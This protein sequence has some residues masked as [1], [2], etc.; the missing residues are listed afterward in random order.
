MLRN[1]ADETDLELA[2]MYQSRFSRDPLPVAQVRQ[3]LEQFADAYA[4]DPVFQVLGPRPVVAISGTWHYSEEDLR[5]MT[6]SVASRLQILGTEKSVKGYERVAPVVQGNLYYWSSADPERTPSYETKLQAMSDAV[7]AHCGLWV[8]PVAPGFDARDVGGRS[9]VDRRDGKTL[10]SSW[11]ASTASAPDAL[12]VI[13]W[14]EY[15]ENTHIEPSTTFGTRYLDVLRELTGVGPRPARRPGAAPGGGVGADD[16]DGVRRHR[17]RAGGHG[18]GGPAAPAQ[19]AVR[20]GSDVPVGRGRGVRR[21]GATSVVLA[22]AVVSLASCGG[23]ATGTADQPARAHASTRP[24]TKET[25]PDVSWS[26]PPSVPLVATGRELVPFS[27]RLLG[28][29]TTWAGGGLTVETT[30]GGYVDDLTEPY[31]DLSSGDSLSLPH[32][33]EAEVLRGRF[34]EAP[35]LFVL[36]REPSVQ[37]PCD[38]HVLLVK[39]A[40]PTV[41]AEL[42]ARLQ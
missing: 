27:P 12:G 5:F 16:A 29:H 41:E 10:R 37:P 1:V 9:V 24:A 26:P 2:I 13:S 8:A 33:V 19:H 25:C 36:W 22:T 17:L 14:N 28:V 40:D 31:D 21:L 11:E 7:H 20:E 18:H 32:G 42:L 38:V 34:Q 30:A 15:S 23:P 4:D 39:G 6:E 3:D 35:L